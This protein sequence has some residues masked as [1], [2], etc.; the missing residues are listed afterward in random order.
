MDPKG[1]ILRDNANLENANK[2]DGTATLRHHVGLQK[3]MVDGRG[4]WCTNSGITG[5]V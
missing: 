2:D 5:T 4:S 1:R 3:S